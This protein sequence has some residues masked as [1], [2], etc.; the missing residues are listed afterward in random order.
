MLFRS[1]EWSAVLVLKGPCTVVA[2]PDGEV[3]SHDRP[4]PALA[5]AGTGDVLSGCIAALLAS[6]LD[7]FRAACAGVAVHGEAAALVASEVGE[8]GALATDVL[9]RLPRA[10]AALAAR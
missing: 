7:P 6:G 10:I 3:F 5:T 2:S 8:R 1:R 9:D 4:N